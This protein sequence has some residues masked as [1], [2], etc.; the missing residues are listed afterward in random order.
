M[1]VGAAVDSVSKERIVAAARRRFETYGY[2]RTSIAEIA[3]D[4]GIAVGTIYRYFAGKEA[5]FLGVVEHLNRAWL[6]ESRRALDGPGTAADRLQRLG[7]ASIQFAADNALITA[8][9]MRDTDIVFAPLLE[10]V[11]EE[12]QR[13]NVAMIADV[14]RDGIREGTFRDVDPVHAAYVLFTAGS[15]LSVQRTYPYAE[16]MPVFE[17]IVYQGLLTR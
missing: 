8:I 3:R 6:T 17:T 5:V 13:Q 12:M 16:L 15:I 7:A 14:V 10:R 1:V 4:A 9:A 2:R 11:H